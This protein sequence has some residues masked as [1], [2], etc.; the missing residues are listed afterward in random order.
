MALLVSRWNRPFLKARVPTLV[1]ITALGFIISDLFLL[2]IL[3]VAAHAQS[4]VEQATTYCV[5]TLL[6]FVL[7]DVS[8]FWPTVLRLCYVKRVNT[9]I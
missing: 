3:A 8:V 1:L 9:I 6:N 5:L 4:L 2:S 7:T